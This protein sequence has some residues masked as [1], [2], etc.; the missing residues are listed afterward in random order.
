MG[1]LQSAINKLSSNLDTELRWNSVENQ[2]WNVNVVKTK[3]SIKQK[4]EH[5]LWGAMSMFTSSR[6]YRRFSALPISRHSPWVRFAICIYLDNTVFLYDSKQPNVWFSRLLS[7]PSSFRGFRYALLFVCFTFQKQ[8]KRL[9]ARINQWFN[10]A[11]AISK[12]IL[13]FQLKKRV[14]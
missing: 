8:P 14:L 4:A 10:F 1:K 9:S 2:K 13:S 3:Q 5:V 7:V 6:N 11:V 12:V